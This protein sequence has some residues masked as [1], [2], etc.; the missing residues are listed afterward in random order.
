MTRELEDFIV[1]NFDTAISSGHIKAFYQPIF[2]ALTKNVSC[3]EALSR[4]EDPDKGMLSPLDFISVL[5]KHDLI[6]KLDIYMLKCICETY[7]KLSA[8]ETDIPPFSINLSRCDFKDPELFQRFKA[9]L[10]EYNVPA[11]AIRVEVTESVMLNEEYN[12]HNILQKF[13]SAGFAV[14]MDDFGSGY[15]SLNVLKDYEFDL[16]KID[17][18]FL[19]DFD[20]RSK[21]MLTAVINMA[22]ILGIHTLSEGVETEEQYRFLLDAG[23]EYLQ[24]YYFSKPLREKDYIEFLKTHSKV[25][26]ANKEITYWDNVGRFNFLSANPLESLVLNKNFIACQGEEG[27]KS[28]IALALLEYKDGLSKCIYY[29]DA[30]FERIRELGYNSVEEIESSF[31]AR[32]AV[33]H[34]MMEESLNHSIAYNSVERVD[35]VEN[36]VFFTIKSKCIS[37]CGDKYM[38]AI[39]LYTFDA[40]PDEHKGDEIL[41]YGQSLF[42]TYNLISVVYPNADIAKNIYNYKGIGLEG[43]SDM[44]LESGIKTFCELDVHPDDRARYLRLFDIDALREYFKNS[45][46][47]FVQ[48]AF[49]L[50]DINGEYSWQNVRLTKLTDPAVESYMYTVQDIS[51]WD[52]SFLDAI[53]Q[54]DPDL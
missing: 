43:Y 13:Q 9:V 39:A 42:L 28:K 48:Q 29:N 5:E 15:S 36:D 17:M 7:N 18:I 27:L 37:K 31:N 21:Q 38:I 54:I 16:L 14:W 1:N 45:K 35:Y 49:R 53:G 40:D 25:I 24:G 47:N 2:R 10:N 44:D 6:T 52:I 12:F 26:E 34:R 20:H 30:Y 23:C 19:K 51:D 22:K 32:D 8:Y 3:V 11:S 46:R 33:Q 4:W 50:K 41:K